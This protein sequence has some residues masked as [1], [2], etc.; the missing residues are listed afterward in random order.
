M[1]ARPARLCS[2]HN[3]HPQTNP[4]VSWHQQS[5]LRSDQVAQM[6]EL[7][8]KATLE[9]WRTHQPFAYEMRIVQDLDDGLFHEPDEQP[10][11]FAFQVRLPLSEGARSAVC[12]IGL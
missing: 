5:R 2:I 1:I 10:L 3:W 11:R 8:P 7:A 12:G 9:V 4:Q 6:S